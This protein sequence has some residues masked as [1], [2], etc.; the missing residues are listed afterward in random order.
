MLA[1]R[2]KLFRFALVGSSLTL[3]PA[4]AMNRQQKALV[5]RASSNNLIPM[6]MASSLRTKSPRKRNRSPSGSSATPTRTK[7]ANSR[8]AN[9]KAA[10]PSSPNPPVKTL[11]ERA[12][13]RAARYGRAGAR[14]ALENARSQRD[15][16]HQTG[17]RSRRTARTFHQDARVGRLKQRR[18]ALQGRVRKV[19]G[20]HDAARRPRR[21]RPKAHRAP[22]VNA[23]VNAARKVALTVNASPKAG[24]RRADGERPQA[25]PRDSDRP[26]RGSPRANV[27]KAVL[28]AAPMANAPTCAA[29]GIVRSPDLKVVLREPPG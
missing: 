11:P 8:P 9:L 13:S 22:Q 4:V 28:K 16:H 3:A 10:S 20:T 18:R 15:G 12:I 1:A 24:R 27:R 23:R 2:W 19:C 7:T 6:A 5:R 17:R 21:E 25:G 29:R 14:T 26:R